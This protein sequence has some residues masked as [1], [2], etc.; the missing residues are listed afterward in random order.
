MKSNKLKTFFATLSIS[1]ML[2]S[3]V[4]ASTYKIIPGD[5]LIK[6]SWLFDTS[7]TELKADNNLK[8][9]TIYYGKT[10]NV[11]APYYTV[12]SGDSLH[13]IAKKH[14]ISLYALRRAN[15][16]WTSAIYPGEKLII[17]GGKAAASNTTT[18]ATPAK[19][20]IPYTAAELDLLARLVRAEAEN[21]PYKAKVAVA[22]VVINRV[23]SN[24]FP[25]NITSVVNQVINGYYQ[26]TPVKN[27]VIKN[28][29]RA[30]DRQ[31]ALEA[32]NGSDPSKGALFY[33]DD[34]NTNRW[35]WSKP[36]LARYD[37]MVF[38]Q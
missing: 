9:N 23:Q 27:G 33:F 4:K 25:N 31:A 11:S 21:Q 15:N 18:K 16:R 3:P 2:F 29:A 28:P 37:K 26:F 38:V 35:L 24:Q 34:S 22:A 6:L 14:E 12:K 10:L 17:P 19:G 30:E 32:L 8:G 5:S 13:S 1:A 36:L 7:V 20:V